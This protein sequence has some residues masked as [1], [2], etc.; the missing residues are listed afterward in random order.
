MTDKRLPCDILFEEWGS[1]GRVRPT[2]GHLFFLLQECKLY[3]AADYVAKILHKSSPQRPNFGPAAKIRLTP[4]ERKQIDS[5][6]TIISNGIRYPLIITESNTN[7]SN[8]STQNASNVINS[9]NP[10][11]NLHVNNTDETV[12]DMI[13]WSSEKM[14]HFSSLLTSGNAGLQS[15][16]TDCIPHFSTLLVEVENTNYPNLSML[17][18]KQSTQFNIAHENSNIPDFDALRN[19]ASLTE[20]RGISI[21]QISRSPLPSLSLNTLLK[22]YPYA[23]LEVATNYFNETPY[24][25][26][27]EG[28]STSRGRLLGSGAFS[29]VY[30][31]FGLVNKP[32]AVKRLNLKNINIVTKQFATEV[33]TFYKYKHDHLV[34]L[35]GYSCD[36]MAYCLLYEYIQGGNLTNRLQVFCFI[37]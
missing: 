24:V 33:E 2:L 14:P 28:S 34:P 22:H 16:I 9:T 18:D 35:L 30:L 6:N 23:E 25:S 8:F 17:D 5:S 31:A 36:G 11:E 7:E 19:S 10:I 21:P 27:E 12:S 3:A 4:E 37:L 26:A 1:S 32:V 15:S 20:S 13:Q 29:S